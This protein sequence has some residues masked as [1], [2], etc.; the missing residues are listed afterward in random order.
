MSLRGG[1]LSP[2][3]MAAIPLAQRSTARCVPYCAASRARGKKVR[4]ACGPE[5]TSHEPAQPR[6]ALSVPSS[7][8]SGTAPCSTTPPG[9]GDPPAAGAPTCPNSS[10]VRESLATPCQMLIYRDGPPRDNKMLV[11][12]CRSSYGGSKYP[13][14]VRALWSLYRHAQ[15]C[16]RQHLGGS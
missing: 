11:I 16:V 5:L 8:L 15:R 1:T 12:A 4:V 6:C 14:T 7:A 10:R 3:S 9:S 13:L 2:K